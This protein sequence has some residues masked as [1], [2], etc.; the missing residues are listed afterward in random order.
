[1]LP[2]RRVLDLAPGLIKDNQNEELEQL[3]R[4]LEGSMNW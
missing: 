2:Q 3:S 1:M 4:I